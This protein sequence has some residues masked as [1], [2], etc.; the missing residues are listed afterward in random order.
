MRVSYYF[1]ITAIFISNF[2]FCQ[3][4]S[5]TELINASKKYYQGLK[6]FSINV[7]EKRKPPV[8]EDTAISRVSCLIDNQ[9]QSMLF[10]PVKKNY[11]IFIMGL[12]E[13]WID[14]DSNIYRYTK[15][16]DRKFT[17]YNK[18]H[19]FYPFVEIDNFF[20]R[21]S[22][23]ILSLSE[24][25]TE[26]ILSNNSYL[27]EFRK[28][29]FSIKKFVEFGYEK[30][31]KGSWYQET[32]FNECVDNDT[33]A[34]SYIN[35]AVEIVSMSDNEK[36]YW[37][38]KKHIAPTT[39]DRSVFD[40]TN[41]RIVNYKDIVIENKIIFLDFFYSSCIP[42]YKSHPS[43]NKLFEKGDGNFI[44]IGID[45]MLS[46]TL[47]IKQFLE[48]FDI[49]HPVIIGEGARQISQIPG[50]V[51]GYPTFL[52]IDIDGKVLEY[53]NGHSENFFRDIEKKYFNKKLP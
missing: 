45:P 33:L 42:C 26:Y 23:K 5:K 29:N 41:L 48:R 20:S 4:R 18:S 28:N 12:K 19:Q 3:I 44:V 49:K 17:A 7:L 8:A 27:Y 16:K 2:C 35:K 21:I 32:N 10:L 24:T 11:G 22:M 37:S 30:K 39:F 31:Y 38:K 9:N 53:R 40:N 1:L 34:A 47:H 52:V 43:V 36:D 14:L 13:Y 51:N 50:V 15:A 6:I 46:D 25:S